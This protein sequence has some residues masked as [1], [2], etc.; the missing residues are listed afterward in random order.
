MTNEE[1]KEILEDLCFYKKNFTSKS[2]EEAISRGVIALEICN[3]KE[4]DDMEQ[5]YANM[6]RN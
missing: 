3:N 4:I 6:K 5:F 2:I 1:A